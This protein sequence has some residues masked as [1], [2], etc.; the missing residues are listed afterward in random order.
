VKLRKC[1]CYEPN[2]TDPD[3]FLREKVILYIFLKLKQHLHG[4]L[5][6][7]AFNIILIG[8]W[9]TF[10]KKCMTFCQG[11]ARAIWDRIISVPL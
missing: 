5:I 4:K 10:I 8:A 6:F 11:K 3:L 2:D 7:C 9:D 1:K